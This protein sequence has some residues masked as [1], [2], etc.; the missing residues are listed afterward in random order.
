MGKVLLWAM[1]NHFETMNKFYAPN[2]KYFIE[3][4][5]ALEQLKQRKF[6]TI[7]DEDEKNTPRK[8][9]VTI[10]K[11][12]QTKVRIRKDLLDY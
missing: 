6:N 3:E 2:Q 1:D 12:L 5:E 8:V 9:K 7:Y 11:C 10:G 4:K